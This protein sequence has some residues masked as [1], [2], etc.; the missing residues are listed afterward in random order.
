[1]LDIASRANAVII[2]VNN[3]ALAGVRTKNMLRI[4]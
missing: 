1:M 2:A 3:A 4:R